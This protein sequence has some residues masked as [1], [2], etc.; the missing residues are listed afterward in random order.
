MLKTKTMKKKKEKTKE[1]IFAMLEKKIYRKAVARHRKIIE[2]CLKNNG[3]KITEMQNEL[4]KTRCKNFIFEIPF[5]D[6]LEIREIEIKKYKDRLHN[7]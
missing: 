6:I 3:L 4:F 5:I 2:D 1:Q 7:L